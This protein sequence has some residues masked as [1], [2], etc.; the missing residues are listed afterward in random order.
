MLKRDPTKKSWYNGGGQWST[1]TICVL[2]T[3]RIRYVDT[4]SFKI[5]RYDRSYMH[6]EK[7]III[8]KNIINI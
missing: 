3:I 4:F 2:D 5:I 7:C 1:N 8:L 6:V